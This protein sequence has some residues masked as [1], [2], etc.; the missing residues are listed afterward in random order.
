MP[1]PDRDD[2]GPAPADWAD[3]QARSHRP[4]AQ[5]AIRAAIRAGLIRVAPAAGGRVRIV[6][7]QAR[8]GAPPSGATG[9]DRGAPPEPSPVAVTFAC[10]CKNRL[11]A[12]PEAAGRQ[13]RCPDCYR[14][15]FVPNLR[16]ILRLNP[17]LP[18][19]GVPPAAA[20][21]GPAGVL[22]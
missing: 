7:R 15:L 14:P 2:R 12:N 16:V 22:G 11:R 5:A 1:T 9:R 20:P 17:R 13:V 10:R 21:C 6:P 4:E 18:I 19:A 8:A 3:L